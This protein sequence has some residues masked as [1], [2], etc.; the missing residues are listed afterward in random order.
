[1]IHIDDRHIELGHIQ[2]YWSWEYDTIIV[3]AR[4]TMDITNFRLKLDF[5]KRHTKTGLGAG[6]YNTKI[7]SYDVGTF[8]LPYKSMISSMLS[9]HKQ[10]DRPFRRDGWTTEY[11]KGLKLHQLFDELKSREQVI[12]RAVKLNKIKKLLKTI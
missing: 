1:M 8:F 6:E 7:A 2:S 12:M 3:T 9:Q 4:L 11:T 5:D 10:S